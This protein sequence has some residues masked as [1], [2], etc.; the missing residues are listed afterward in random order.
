M[1]V[2][3]RSAK[4]SLYCR[5]FHIY[6]SH[7]KMKKEAK[8]KRRIQENFKCSF[9]FFSIFQWSMIQVGSCWKMVNFSFNH[10]FHNDSL[11]PQIQP[12]ADRSRAWKINF[13]YQGKNR[14]FSSTVMRTSSHLRCTVKL[15]EKTKNL[16][17]LFNFLK[18]DPK[19]SKK[20]KRDFSWL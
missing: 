8:K 9:I 1:K 19:Y 15:A 20:Q 2:L 13:L 7:L 10:H 3:F 12:L 4:Y 17:E 11:S 6:F 16:F 18:I 5:F 14:Y